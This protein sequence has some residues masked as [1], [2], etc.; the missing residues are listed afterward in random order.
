MLIETS[1]EIKERDS[2]GT[3]GFSARYEEAFELF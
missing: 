1:V 2:D 3:D